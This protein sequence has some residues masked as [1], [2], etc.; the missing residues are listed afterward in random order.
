MERQVGGEG[1]HR[2]L[3]PGSSVPLEHVCE[4]PGNTEQNGEQREEGAAEERDKGCLSALL[5][6]FRGLMSPSRPRRVRWWFRF[7]YAAV[8]LVLGAALAGAMGYVVQRGSEVQRDRY[9]AWMIGGLCSL[10]AVT[11]SLYGIILHLDNYS[12]PRLQRWVIRLLWMVPVYSISSFCSLTLYLDVFCRDNPVLNADDYI[13]FD[14]IREFY[15]AFAIFSFLRLCLAWLDEAIPGGDAVFHIAQRNA[16]PFMPPF[17]PGEPVGTG[18]LN[19]CRT[20][21]MDYV[22][23]QLVSTVVTFISVEA[24]GG[25]HGIFGQGELFNMQK[26][27]PYMVIVRLLSSLFLS[28]S[29]SPK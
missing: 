2:S 23:V 24:G 10:A 4:R 14:T 16:K 7:L 28:S 21:T 26:M 1:E 25:A 13:L 9:I 15:E 19:F 3:P 22:V 6:P 8:V 5:V 18:F 20:G 11:I 29:S 12:K 17:R 27:Y